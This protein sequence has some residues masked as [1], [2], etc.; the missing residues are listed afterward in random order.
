[1]AIIAI[2]QTATTIHLVRLPATNEAKAL[3]SGAA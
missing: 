1:M 3:K 2:T